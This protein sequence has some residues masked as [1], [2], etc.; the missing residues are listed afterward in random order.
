M[1]RKAL[2]LISAV[3]LLVA[4]IALAHEGMRELKGT[5]A[6]VSVESIIVTHTDG[7]TNETVG[8]TG[9]TTYQ[10]GHAAG[11][12]ADLRVGSR[13]VVHFGRDGKALAIHLPG[14]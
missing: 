8:L 10:V 3:L 9:T 12:H 6:A 14:K 2:P 4:Q 11:S 5:I 1:T 7:K 13:V